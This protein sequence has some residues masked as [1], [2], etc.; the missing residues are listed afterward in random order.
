MKKTTIILS[1]ILLA[2]NLF[3]FGQNENLKYR[4]ENRFSVEGDGGWDYLTLDE[5]TGRL[6][7]SHGIIT[8][9]LDSKTGKLL[10]TIKDT[11]GVHGI[12]LDQKENKAFISCGRDSSVSIINLTTLEFIKKVKVTGA[13]PDAILFDKFSDRVFVFNG[14][15]ANATVIDAKTDMIVATL[16]LAGKPEFSASDEN[17]KVFVNIEDKSLITVIDSKNLKVENTWPLAPGEEPSGLSIDNTA[18]LLFSVCNNKKMVVMN[19]Q[20]GAIMSVLNIGEG[21][22]GC[23]FDSGLKRA[24]SSNGEGTVTVVQEMNTNKFNVLE[25]I[26]TNKSARTICVDNK[27]HHIYLPT[28]EFGSASQ[29]TAENQ[30]PRPV[31]KP[32]SFTILDIAPFR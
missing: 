13:N 3:C 21:T 9:V 10:G 1:C 27:T 18:H 11:K 5:N 32:G 29:P 2:T 14:R 19:A 28:A 7:I 24:Y 26:Q 17:G 20:N 22:D 4:I 25:T 23:A 30:R 12:A 8:Q 15:S 6:F 31:I 16:P